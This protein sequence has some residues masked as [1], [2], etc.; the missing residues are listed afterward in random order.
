MA[1]SS[2]FKTPARS[3]KRSYLPRIGRYWSGLQVHRQPGTVAAPERIVLDVA[4]GVT[5]SPEP[6]VRIFIGTEPAQRAAERVLLWSIEQHRDP[7]RVYEIYLMQ[8][9][10]GFDRRKWKTGFTNYRCAIPHYAGGKGRAIWNDVDQIYLVDPAELFDT[11]MQGHAFLAI[12][13]QE[14][15]VMLMDCERML[16][17]WPLAEVQHGRRKHLIEKAVR[18]P[19]VW[20]QLGS[21]WNARD[22]EYAP[23]R[24]KLIH[25]TT[26]HTQ[27]WRPYPKL[28]KYRE[29][30]DPAG[31]AAAN[32]WYSEQKKADAAQ[33]AGRKVAAHV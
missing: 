10:M 27:P 16:P 18:I 3:R 19:G 23:E 9:L 22:A 29:H 6:P 5:P 26:L 12:T 32:V 25:Y 14:S 1:Q 31:R 17:I 21:E 7:A 24:S 33:F 13:R 2:E 11:D 4:D 28:L 15:A 8:D 30:W 20:G